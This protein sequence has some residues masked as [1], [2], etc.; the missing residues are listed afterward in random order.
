MLVA[1]RC[2]SGKESGHATSPLCWTQSANP[3]GAAETGAQARIGSAQA[4]DEPRLQAR[5]AVW[6]VAGGISTRDSARNAVQ[7]SFCT[8]SVPAVSDR[9]QPALPHDDIVAKVDQLM[10]LCADL[11]AKLRARD[12][13]AAKLA[14]ALVAEVLG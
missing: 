2:L 1:K 5:A 8:A 7:L 10:A 14:E 13:K 11:E 12:E 3:G 4:I 6:K 9:T